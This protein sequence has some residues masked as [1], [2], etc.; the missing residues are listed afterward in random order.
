MKTLKAEEVNAKT[1]ATIEDA[2]AEI[3]GFIETVYNV[4]RL[5]SALEY[6]PPAEF[7]ADLDRSRNPQPKSEIAVSPK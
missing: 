1:Y 5:H 2:R 6:K 4:E 7:E 3:G